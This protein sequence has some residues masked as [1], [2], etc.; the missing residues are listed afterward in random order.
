[1]QRRWERT[2][3]L[4]DLCA[5]R[6]SG[7]RGLFLQ[8]PCTLHEKEK[9]IIL[10]AQLASRLHLH[11]LNQLTAPGQVGVGDS[12]PRPKALWAGKV[13]FRLL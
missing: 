11:V 7:S 8:S 6:S 5:V 3:L 9:A 13:G 1:M 2:A 10:L 12:C 4:P